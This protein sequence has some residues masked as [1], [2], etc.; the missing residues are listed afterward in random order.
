MLLQVSYFL[1]RCL[2]NA[3]MRGIHQFVFDVDL[4]VRAL[5]TLR[6]AELATHV[7]GLNQYVVAQKPASASVAAAP[8]PRQAP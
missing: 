6:F 5:R 7:D 2:L 1:G 8:S 4:L 3:E